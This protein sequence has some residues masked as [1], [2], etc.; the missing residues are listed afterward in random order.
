MKI[1]NFDDEWG[2]VTTETHKKRVAK[3]LMAREIL[4]GLQILLG[5]M[6]KRAY[7][8]LKRIYQNELRATQ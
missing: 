1:F 8:V 2:F 6:E 5:K 3:D 7:L 4:F